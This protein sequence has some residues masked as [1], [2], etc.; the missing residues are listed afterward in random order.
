MNLFIFT[1]LG[2]FG[3]GLYGLFA[4][5]AA[6]RKI[7]AANVMGTGVFVV[8]IALAHRTPNV[9]PIPHALVLTGIVISVSATAFALALAKR[10]HRDQQAAAAGGNPSPLSG[11]AVASLDH[12]ASRTR[13]A[14]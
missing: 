5:P 12:P 11:Q 14:S 3:M 9:D 7:I 2:L 6:L 4:Y 1:G 10:L 8:L 13:T